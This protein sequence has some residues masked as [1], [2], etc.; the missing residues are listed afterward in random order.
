MINVNEMKDEQL[1]IGKLY[2]KLKREQ[3]NDRK[4]WQI[5]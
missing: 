1:N 5:I 4:I 3:L 2:Q